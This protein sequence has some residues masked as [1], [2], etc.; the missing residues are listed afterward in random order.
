M[1][2]VVCH[3]AGGAEIVSS[4]LLHKGHS[5]K[6]ILEGP[7]VSIFGKKFPKLIKSSSLKDSINKCDWILCGT[8]WQSE[9]ELQAI[10]LG[11]NLGKK[12][13][14]V[15]DHWV[16]YKERFLRGRKLI[17]PDEI[18][19][20]DE[21][22]KKIAEENFD[23]IIISEIL[24]YYLE[25]LK[26]IIL[27]GQKKLIQERPPK[28]IRVLY[29][30]EPLGEQALLQHGNDRHWGY[31]EF[32]ALEYFIR[33][34][35]SIYSD[36]DQITLRLHPAEKEGKYKG[37][38]QKYPNWLKMGVN[39]PLIEQVNHFDVL[40]GCESMA[41][42]IGLMAGKR[43]ISCIP[44]EGEKCILPHKKIEHLSDFTATI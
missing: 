36:V 4:W 12:S 41:M 23:G 5:F 34:I 9:I 27:E 16:C 30:C 2:A 21:E 35:K 28:G 13:I 1:I 17:L 6:A 39:I 10:T 43:V 42:I 33:N 18:W 29:I 44:P 31:N 38:M 32:D 26:K 7:A 19:V 14:S 20:C 11:R 40:V 22:A 37:V 15:L 24:N 8:S 25:D 3:D